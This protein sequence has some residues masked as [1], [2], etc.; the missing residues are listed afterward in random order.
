MTILHKPLHT[1][2]KPTNVT[3]PPDVI[4]K[5]KLVAHAEDRSFSNALAQ[6][7]RRATEG[8]ENQESVTSS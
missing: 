2:V 8:L 4:Q 5:V 3:L 6:L 7:V 1:R